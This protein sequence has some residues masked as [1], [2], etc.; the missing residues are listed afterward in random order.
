VKGLAAVFF[1]YFACLAPVVA[2]GGLMGAITEGNV[3]TVD[4]HGYKEEGFLFPFFSMR[5]RGSRQ[6]NNTLIPTDLLTSYDP[7]SDRRTLRAT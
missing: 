4:W 3:S 6:R 1:L 5:L 2:F 7:L